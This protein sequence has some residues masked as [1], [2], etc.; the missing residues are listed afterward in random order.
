MNHLSNE[1]AVMANEV[2]TCRNHI[3]QRLNKIDDLV[4]RCRGFIPQKE[5]HEIS[6]LTNE[7]RHLLED[8]L[9]EE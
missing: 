6:Q 1:L 3:I 4:E 8:P 9:S 7:T 5:M 2:D